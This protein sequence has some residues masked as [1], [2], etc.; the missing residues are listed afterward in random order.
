MVLDST[1]RRESVPAWR[2]CPLAWLQHGPEHCRRRQACRRQPRSRRLGS[3][4]Q[5]QACSPRSRWRQECCRWTRQRQSAHPMTTLRCALSTRVGFVHRWGHAPRWQAPPG[6]TQRQQ[7]RGLVDR[8]SPQPS[9][10][11]RSESPAPRYARWRQLQPVAST[12]SSQ[13]RSR[14]TLATAVLAEQSC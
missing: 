5:C 12:A 4:G 9:Q 1:S 13:M 14:L 10:T 2:C 11:L 7:C 6:R 8:P 3:C